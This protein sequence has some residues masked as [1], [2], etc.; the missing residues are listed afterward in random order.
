MSPPRLK[1]KSWHK[2]KGHSGGGRGHGHLG[3]IRKSRIPEQKL[4]KLKILNREKYSDLHMVELHD[5]KD[6]EKHGGYKYLITHRAISHHAF[7]RDDGLNRFLRR[8]GLKKVLREKGEKINTYRLEGTYEEISMAGTAKQLDSFGR[9]RKMTPTKILSNAQYTRAYYK[10]GKIY[11]L[12][13][14]YPRREFDY[15]KTVKTH[16]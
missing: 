7:R 3:V 1:K 10:N 5:P 15:F 9:K 14:N 11:Y 12:N 6:R 13:V 16:G 4:G 2:D 8:T